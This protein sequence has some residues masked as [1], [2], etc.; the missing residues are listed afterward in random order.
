MWQNPHDF[1]IWMSKIWNHNIIVTK[2]T[3]HRV[4]HYLR[5]LHL[6]IAILYSGLYHHLVFTYEQTA[7]QR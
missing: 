6:F 5:T 1:R 7:A 2:F 3:E 4:K